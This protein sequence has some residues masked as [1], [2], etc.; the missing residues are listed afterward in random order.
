MMSCMVIELGFSFAG[1]QNQKE[2][3]ISYKIIF[4]TRSK[5][6]SCSGDVK[7]ALPVRF[8]RNF[9]SGT[10]D[11]KNVILNNTSQNF[12]AENRGVDFVE[13]LLRLLLWQ[14]SSAVPLKDI[15]PRAR[16]RKRKSIRV[17][18]PV[19]VILRCSVESRTD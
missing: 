3:A 8:K 4:V 6:L 16:G 12:S 2:N 19:V 13:L 18:Q 9:S 10:E 5:H 11:V 14:P 15:A 7:F 1:S 17:C